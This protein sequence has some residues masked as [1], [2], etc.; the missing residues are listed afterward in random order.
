M[1]SRVVKYLGLA[2]ALLALPLVSFGTYSLIAAGA[3]LY[4][5]RWA[6]VAENATDYSITNTGKQMVWL[7]T[8][9]EEKYK[10]KQ[11]VDTFFVRFGDLVQAAVVFVGTAWLGFGARGFA[12]TNL[13][14]IV[15]WFLVALML[16]REHRR[17]VQRQEDT[18]RAV[19]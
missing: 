6:K 2:G 12:L 10:A 11:A 16:L 9:R 5:L 14:F 15:V 13:T 7:P 1:V 8:S 3:G 19:A 4:A 18:A 17:I